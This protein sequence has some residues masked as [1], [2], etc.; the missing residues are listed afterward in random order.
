MLFSEAM[1]K[2]I[3]AVYD[4]K[5]YDRDYL[6]RATG[7]EEMDWHFHDFRLD[8]ETAFAATGA[9]AISVFVNDV[10]DREVL[11][12][13]AA[14]GVGMVA[15]RCAGF[16]NVDLEAAKQLK[17]TVTRVPSYS[18]HAVAEHT[19]ASLMKRLWP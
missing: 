16:N 5:P 9:Q 17:V 11:K 7:A 2:P 12:S 14:S 4:T 13:L 8:R 10:V 15:L 3:I 18:P 1:A 19:I 6:T